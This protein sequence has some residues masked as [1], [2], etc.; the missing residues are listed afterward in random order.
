MLQSEFEERVGSIAGILKKSRTAAKMKKLDKG[1][2]K[3]DGEFYDGFGRNLN[4]YR[5]NRVHA[6]GVYPTLLF[7]NIAPN[8]S[9]DE[10][11]YIK[12]TYQSV[13][14]STFQKFS[15][16]VKRSF[17]NGN[18]EWKKEGTGNDGTL[19]EFKHY[20]NTQIGKYKSLQFFMSNLTDEKLTDANAICTI[21]P[22]FSID[23]DEESKVETI[24]NVD[25]VPVI[26]HTDRVFFNDGDDFIVESFEKSI[27]MVA[28]KPE[29]VGVI[30]VLYSEFNIIWATQT[31]KL[32]DWTF[33]Y[34][35]WEHGVGFTPAVTLSGDPFLVKDVLSFKS[36]FSSAVPNLN[37]AT[38]DNA[39]ML[40]IKRKVGYPTRVFI[41]EDCRYQVSGVTCD[42]GFIKTH[43]GAEKP[44]T[45]KCPGCQG[46]GK[47]GVFGPMSELRIKAA[48]NDEPQVRASDAMA[49]ISPS[50]DIPKFLREEINAFVDKSE[51]IL[52]LKAEP[53]GQ[54]NITATEKNQDAKNCEAFIKPISD[55]IWYIYGYIIRAMG[56]MMYD[57]DIFKSIMPTVNRA[58]RFH[59]V[60]A[61]DLMLQIGE[62]IKA[63]LPQIA[64][65]KILYDFLRS[66]D[67]EETFSA[68]VFNLLEQADPLLASSKEEVALGLSRGTIE[69]WEAVLH[70][71]GLYF[72]M[73]LFRESDKFFEQPI[74]KQIEAIQNLAKESV[75]DDSSILIPEE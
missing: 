3:E 12:S 72:A 59:L 20:L 18:I 10:Q 67:Y 48:E 29:K 15:N 39:N 13:T 51:D 1:V 64:I 70:Q 42:Q 9:D 22:I 21:N 6:K 35:A 69:K 63:G 68:Q 23:T 14:E 45:T 33:S 54:G 60:Q 16:T 40:V 5:E 62:G 46:S 53:R 43:N 7:K 65:T 31:G 56:F 2:L 25:S 17:V 49:Y 55:Q 52:H 61:E 74:E 71:K 36:P 41:S 24:T 73:Q 4:E 37:L 47:V 8:Q 75:P 27:V 58:E 50:V 11:A 30:I 57:D 66:S 44:T 32:E 28:D 19:D 26:Y 34:E 38:L